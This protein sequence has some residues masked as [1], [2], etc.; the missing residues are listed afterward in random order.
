MSIKNPGKITGRLGDK[1]LVTLT[2]EDKQILIFTFL[3]DAGAFSTS[4]VTHDFTSKMVG[5]IMNDVDFSVCNQALEKANFINAVSSTKLQSIFGTYI[6]AEGIL[7]IDR[8]DKKLR[9][10]EIS[11]LDYVSKKRT[12]K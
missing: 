12:H 1:P 10:R 8:Y 2:L 7:E 6:T 11:D 3:K 9:D 4:V 5:F